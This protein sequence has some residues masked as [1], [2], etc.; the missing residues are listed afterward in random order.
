VELNI[1]MSLKQSPVLYFKK[2]NNFLTIQKLPD[3]YI[4]QMRVK[5]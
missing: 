1:T 5:F 2:H 4:L 3:T